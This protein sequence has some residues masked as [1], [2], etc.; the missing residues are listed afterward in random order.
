M[1]AQTCARIYE[2]GHAGE[3]DRKGPMEGF[4]GR[5][6]KGEMQLNYNLKNKQINKTIYL[7]TIYMDWLD[8]AVFV[9]ALRRYLNYSNTPRK[10]QCRVM[11]PWWNLVVQMKNVA[12]VACKWPWDK[13]V[14]GHKSKAQCLFPKRLPPSRETTVCH[15][16]VE[17]LLC[18]TFHGV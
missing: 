12:R 4:G 5:K 16:L 3:G 6:K 2:C 10:T 8:S 18:V 15:H 13:Y 7:V 17:R 11:F 9:K 14:N 1:T